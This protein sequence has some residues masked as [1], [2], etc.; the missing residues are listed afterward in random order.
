M[1][2][3]RRPATAADLLG[4]PAR[5]QEIVITVPGEKGDTEFAMTLK[6]VSASTYDRLLAEHPP[7]KEQE[8]EGSGYNPDTFAPAVI[9]AVVS[10]PALSLEQAN[11]IWTGDSWSRGELRDLFMACVNL[12]AKGLDV[13]FTSAG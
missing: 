7:T 11:E 5:T 13:P 3:R 4:K 1:A 12:C 8:K 10:D 9:A 6:A 2:S